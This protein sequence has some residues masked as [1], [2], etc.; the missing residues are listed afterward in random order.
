VIKADLLADLSAAKNF[1][2]LAKGEFYQT[3]IDESRSLMQLPPQS[4]AEYDLNEGPRMQTI[5]KLA[6]EDDKSLK[7]FKF[8]LRSF[9]FSYSNFSSLNGLICSGDV[10]LSK[11]N[12]AFKITSSRNHVKS[13]ALWHSLKQ[14]IEMGFQTTFGFRFRNNLFH[15]VGAGHSQLGQSIIS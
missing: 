14:R 4:T 11:N 1:F 13:G 3:F 15:A 9:S 6:L 2:L 10:D 7:R 5:L 8:V 12:S